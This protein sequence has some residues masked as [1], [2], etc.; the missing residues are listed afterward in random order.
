MGD[1]DVDLL[2]EKYNLR[3]KK[4]RP[5][6]K[7]GRVF[8]ALV[9]V[10]AVVAGALSYQVMVTGEEGSLSLFGTLKRLV[11]SSDKILEGEKDDRI[12]IVAM[13]VGGAGHDG[14]ELSDTIIFGSYRPSTDE[15]G[16]L[17]IP[18]DLTVP[19][20]GYGWRKINHINAYEGPEFASNA[21][22][23]LLDQ[24]VHYWVKV[25]FQGF[26]DLVDDLG[27][28]EIYVD[29]AFTDNQYPTD[30]Y[31]V[32][33][34]TFEEGWTDMDGK[35]ALQYV[36]SRHGNN[37]EGSD[38]ARSRRQQKVL[39]AVKDKAISVNTLLNP[40]KIN[41]ILSTLS[42]HIETNLTT[43]EII[44]FATLGR[45]VD[46]GNIKN[47]VLDNSAGSPLYNEILNGA[48]VLLPKNDDWG[49][50]QRMAANIFSP[51][52][53]QY[54]IEAPPEEAP[55][56]VKVEIQ[57]GTN[58][59]GYAFRTSQM[60]EGQGFEVTKI[61]NAA[62]R[63]FDYTLIYDLTN[64][65]RPDELKM[66]QDYLAADVAMT[67]TGWMYTNEIIPQEITVAPDDPD[68]EP[69]EEDIDFLIILGEASANLVMR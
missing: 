14:P 45:D 1:V 64:G 55:T 34:I 3:E 33:T 51:D 41:K 31:L 29:Q 66:L 54:E 62:E 16:M 26:A 8:L 24:E 17:S 52:D 49:P 59:T 58:I 18:R 65:Q 23:N 4:R 22:G 13:G 19:I 36:R 40:S 12:N 56:F 68:A 9:I 20:D 44:R 42:D 48:Y 39:M 2:K 38:F 50:V 57:N 30:D 21:I 43:W 27:G 11:T 67:T 7:V 69:T 28:V 46:P 32:Q 37:G 61:S 60:L 63:G 25:D 15:V 10:F 5:V 47:H 53:E 35:T 6:N